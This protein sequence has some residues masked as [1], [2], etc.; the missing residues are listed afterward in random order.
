[1][2]IVRVAEQY[3]QGTPR[4]EAASVLHHS[5]LIRFV[6]SFYPIPQPP[7]FL[8]IRGHRR[9]DQPWEGKI[10]LLPRLN[11]IGL[12]PFPNHYTMLHRRS[13]FVPWHAITPLKTRQRSFLF[14]ATTQFRRPLGVIHHRPTPTMRERRCLTY[15]HPIPP[16]KCPAHRSATNPI[17]SPSSSS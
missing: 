2:K 4:E 16:S 3:L 1:M 17:C 15:I 13:L 7:K 9:L 14:L 8:S 11:P 10:Y 12:L 5:M 6:G